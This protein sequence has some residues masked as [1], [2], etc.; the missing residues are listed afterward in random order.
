MVAYAQSGYC[1][2]KLLLDYF[3]DAA[4]ST[5]AA[6]R[7]PGAWTCGGCDN[8]MSPPAVQ[9]VE[10]EEPLFE[11]TAVPMVPQLPAFTIGSQVKVPKFDIGT[12]LSV[13]GDQIT[14]EF[15]ENT[16]K[17]FMAE[18]VRPA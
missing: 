5:A 11:E 13:A 3:G 6:P 16:T 2:W 15:P 12:V 1:R 9:P 4:A 14:I 8:C 18:F 7:T 10:D 17:T